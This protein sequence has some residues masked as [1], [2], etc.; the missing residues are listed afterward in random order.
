[1]FLESPGEFLGCSITR[2]LESLGV[3]LDVVKMGSALPGS[4][5]RPYEGGSEGGSIGLP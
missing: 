5:R 2:A 1:V 3:D 4:A